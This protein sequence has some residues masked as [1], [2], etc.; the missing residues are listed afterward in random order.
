[1]LPSIEVLALQANQ[2]EQQ[3]EQLKRDVRNADLS[4]YER[5][6]TI[7]CLHA[8]WLLLATVTSS[9]DHAATRERRNA[10]L[11]AQREVSLG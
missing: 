9:L 10:A 3:A 6:S 7:G 1:M 5:E 2:I 11:A 4:D 8:C